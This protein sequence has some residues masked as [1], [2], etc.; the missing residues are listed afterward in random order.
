MKTLSTRKARLLAAAVVSVGALV[1]TTALVAPASAQQVQTVS[2]S[3]RAG[4]PVVA[5]IAFGKKLHH[6]F[7]PD[8]KGALHSGA[9]TGLD[10]LGELGGHLFVGFQN[11]VGS[12]GE[13]STRGNLNSTIVEFTLSGREV[14]QWDVL[15]KIDGLSTDPAGGTVIATVN[16][17]ASSSLYTVTVGT[18]HVTHYRYSE[19]LPHLGGTDAI[20]IY[21]GKIL[22]SA[23]AP[24]TTGAP[25]PKAAYPAVY[26]VTLNGKTAVA[27]VRPLFYDR[28][29]ARSV[30]APS[31]GKLVHLALTDPDSSEVVPWVSARFAGD[32]MLN[33]QG[34]QELVFDHQAGARVGL[35]VLHLSTAVDDTAWVTSRSGAL[36]TTDSTADSVDMISGNLT[37]GTAYTTVA[38][39][40]ASS[41]PA[42]CPAPGFPASYLGT[43]N[44]ETGALPKVATAGAVVNPKGMIFVKF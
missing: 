8:G 20:S 16:E 34:D 26:V 5:Q 3:A 41:A 9:L 42:T 44:L 14:R 43:V 31:A 17:D 19:R 11:G 27:S 23:S 36:Y 21:Q 18:G 4:M 39:C 12:Q 40:D 28:W 13:P 32:F 6:L 38:P 30:N 35:S 15:G 25:A 1:T 2:V 33:S 7:R 24:G 10:D 37:V 22:V 29:L